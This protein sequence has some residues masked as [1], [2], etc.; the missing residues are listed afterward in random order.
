MASGKENAEIIRKLL[1]VLENSNQ[2]EFRIGTADCN[3]FCA[4]AKSAYR[5]SSA[6]GSGF[7]TAAIQKALGVT[8]AELLEALRWVASKRVGQFGESDQMFWA[9]V[10]KYRNFWPKVP[11]KRQRKPRK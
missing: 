10:P 5:V 7:P 6:K 9:Y 1:E 3:L 11:R 8:E 2:S 4:D